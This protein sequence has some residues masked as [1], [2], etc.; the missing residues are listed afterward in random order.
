MVFFSVISRFQNI[1]QTED[2]KYICTI[3]YPFLSAV[4]TFLGVTCFTLAYVQY[5]KECL[6]NTIFLTPQH[7]SETP[8]EGRWVY[9]YDTFESEIEVKPYDGVHFVFD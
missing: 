6:N 5:E 7:G 3:Q 8:T 4:L 9:D 2:T 1:I